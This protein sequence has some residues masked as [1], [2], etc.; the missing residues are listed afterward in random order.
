VGSVPAAVREVFVK[1]DAAHHLPG[2]QAR[3]AA[4]PSGPGADRDDG[5]AAMSAGDRDRAA[6]DRDQASADRDQTSSDYDQTWSDLDHEASE[7][8]QRGSDRDQLAA[9]R[10]SWRPFATISQTPIPSA[11][12][13]QAMSTAGKHGVAAPATVGRR[14]RRAR[15]RRCSDDGRYDV[16]VTAPVG[17]CGETWGWRSFWTGRATA[18][19]VVAAHLMTSRRT[20]SRTG[21][22]GRPWR[23]T[24]I[25][26]SRNPTRQFPTGP[27]A[28]RAV[29]DEDA[30]RAQQ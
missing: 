5:A 1:A 8:D 9:D 20:A 29:E 25:A 3:L 2:R 6:A 10:D 4:P 18:A 11:G 30:A 14:P 15:G 12:L 28:R 21:P 19:S 22:S 24:A 17:A 13:T 16:G 27:P 7:A 23:S 26:V